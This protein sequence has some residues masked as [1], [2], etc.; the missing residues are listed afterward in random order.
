MKPTV[1]IKIMKNLKTTRQMTG[2]TQREMAMKLSLS[3]NTYLSYEYGYRNPSRFAHAH[4][5]R[6]TRGLLAT[7]PTVDSGVARKLTEEAYDGV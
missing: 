2:M 4:I 5:E 1:L 7:R 6:V 3:Y